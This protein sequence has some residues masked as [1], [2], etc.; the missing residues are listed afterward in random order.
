MRL[1]QGLAFI[2]V[3][4]TLG[5]TLLSSDGLGLFKLG[6]LVPFYFGFLSILEGGTS[7]CVGYA[8]KG[9][10]DLHEKFGFVDMMRESKTRHTVES[11][12]WKRI[13]RLKAR[14]IYLEA[15]GGSALLTIVLFFV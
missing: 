3:F 8:G 11:E 10:Y 14:R 6:L 4:L 13:D 5:L 7:F 12:E 2:G 15:L 9:T 1:A